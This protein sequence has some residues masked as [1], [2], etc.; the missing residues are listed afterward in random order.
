MFRMGLV[1]SNSTHDFQ[2]FVG[3][4]INVQFPGPP[5]WKKVRGD[6]KTAL[7]MVAIL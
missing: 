7:G 5:G 3:K 6:Y 2:T 1:V 4:N